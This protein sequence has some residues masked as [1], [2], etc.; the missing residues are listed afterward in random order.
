[1]EIFKK[2]EKKLETCRGKIWVVGWVG[3]VGR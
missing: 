3:R 1:M 2:R